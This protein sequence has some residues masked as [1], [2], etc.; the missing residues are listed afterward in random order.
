M[1]PPGGSGT[2][3]P[4]D[5]GRRHDRHG[6][7]HGPGLRRG[8]PGRPRHRR[9]D[10]P[11]LPRL[12]RPGPVRHHDWTPATCSTGSATT[13]CRGSRVASPCNGCWTRAST[14]TAGLDDLRRRIAART[15][16][17]RA[18][19]DTA[20]GRMLAELDRRTRRHRR[21]RTRRPVRRGRPAGGDG[22]RPAA[23]RSGRTHGGTVATV[24]AIAGGPTTARSTAERV[25]KDL[26][27][28]QMA[29]LTAGMAVRDARRP[30]PHARDAGRPQRVGGPA[31]PRRGA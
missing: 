31:R 25:T 1:T 7:R 14:A 11:P 22:T 23:P 16:L 6:R 3:R 19:T 15:R 12:R 10:P 21:P 5:A 2:R 20:A 24:A 30:R 13:C 17:A 29:Q 28:A 27:D 9:G 26:L 8:R 4:H 18:A